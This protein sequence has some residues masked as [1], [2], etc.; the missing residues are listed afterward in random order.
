MTK[1][2]RDLA[3]VLRSKNSGPFEVTMDVVFKSEAALILVRDSRM[4][5]PESV[6]AAYGISP[7][8]VKGPYF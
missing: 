4:L 7:W 3:S 8:Q 6:S 1:R 5:S 2:L